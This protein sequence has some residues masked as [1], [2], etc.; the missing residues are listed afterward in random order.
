MFV[1]LLIMIR[2]GGK[3]F[4]SHK[5][6]FDAVLGFMIASMMARAC[7]G[8]SPFWQTISGGFVVVGL[9]RLVSRLAL[10]HHSFGNLVKGHSNL[11]IKDGVVLRD[12]LNA[13]DLSDHDVAEDLRLNGNVESPAQVKLAFFERDGRIS[14][15]RKEK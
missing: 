13:H 6:A 9:H 4:L 11:V 15:V 12:V 7:N 8:S 3:R 5:T 10:H 1:A 14:V 2:L